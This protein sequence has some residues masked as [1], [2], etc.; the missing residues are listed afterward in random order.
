[1]IY[2]DGG[3]VLPTPNKAVGFTRPANMNSARWKIE[4]VDV[5]TRAYTHCLY[6]L[7]LHFDLPLH[8]VVPRMAK[9]MLEATD[10][11]NVAL[12][13]MGEM[14]LAGFVRFERG[15]DE[16]V[17]VPT[18]KFLALNLDCA[19]APDS[20]ISYPIVQGFGKEM[21]EPVIRGGVVNEGNK[22]AMDVVIDI[23]DQEFEVNTFV[24]GLI[25]KYPPVFDKTT[26]AYMYDRALRSSEVLAGLA[27]KFPYFLDSRG[28][29]YTDTTCGMN[30]QGADHEKALLV[31]TYKEVLTEAGFDA[32]VEAA[33]GYSEKPE[34]TTR[35]MANHARYPNEYHDEWMEADKP[36]SYIACAHLI[37]RFLDD[38]TEPLPAF[39]PLDGRC[40]GLQ[41][42][43]AVTRSEAI[44]R[45]LGMHQDEAELDIY[46]K[47]AA[48]WKETLGDEFQ[49][50]ATR[51]AAKVP[52]MTWGYNATMMTSMEHMKKLFGAKTVWN[53]DLGAYESVGEGLDRADCG[54]LGADLYRSLQDTLG[55]LQAA[56]SWVSD[57][58]VVIANSGNAEINWFTPDGFECKQRKVKG[59]RKRL[60]CVLSTKDKFALEILDFSVN[61]PNTA[62]HKSAIAP[63]VIHSLD[64]THLRMVARRLAEL[65]LPMIFIHDSFATHVNHRDVLY[66]IIVDTFAEMYDM[67]YLAMLKED[68]ERTF[69]VSL[70]AVPEMGGLQPSSIKGLKKFFV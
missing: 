4:R 12:R 8:S 55:P 50:M 27:F 53:D 23:A 63:N 5:W 48:E 33:V 68:W 66:D 17:V 29:I 70:E 58:A 41:H 6:S 57:S 24:A 39:I 61:K 59:D 42:W 37:S 56:V 3:I 54:R 36:Y 15:F 2:L 38:P 34:W 22:E 30:P 16:R 62:K 7:P 19:R 13:F 43:S 46:E 51:K 52:V 60:E 35:T 20:T 14:E 1:M 25:K 11:F 28:R 64:A 31:P 67:D 69:C 47:V 44:T 9:K 65:E 49:P 32:L 18:A 45:H 21:P 26:D 10:P 40:S